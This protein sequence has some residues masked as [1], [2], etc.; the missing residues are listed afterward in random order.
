MNDIMNDI[1]NDKKILFSIINDI[2][3]TKVTI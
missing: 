1:V 2:L 3:K